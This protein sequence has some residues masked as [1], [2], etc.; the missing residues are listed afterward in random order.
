MN[1]TKKKIIQSAKIV[2]LTCGPDF[3]MRKVAE[4][5]SISLGNLQY[6]FRT[7]KDLLDS[8]LISNLELYEREFE[9]FIQN[10][11]MEGRELLQF[12][13][14]RLLWEETSPEEDEFDRLFTALTQK[15]GLSEDIRHTYYEKI[16]DMLYRFLREISPGSPDRD[17]H[18]STSLLLPFLE[19]YS[20]LHSHLGA[21]EKELTEILTDTVWS[22]LS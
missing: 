16:Y 13:I 7:K 9:G 2:L 5:A 19:S 20:L 3:S 1:S 18:K 22:I 21:S 17:Y 14:S 10:N 8:L 4:N 11:S 6:Y 15:G 12:G